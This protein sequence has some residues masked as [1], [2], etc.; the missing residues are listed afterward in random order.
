[1]L[2]ARR[3][4]RTLV[5][6]L[7]CFISFLLPSQAL[8]FCMIWLSDTQN[9]SGGYPDTFYTMTDGIVENKAAMDIRFVFHTGD[10]VS[11]SRSEQQWQVAA[12][13]M[14]RLNGKIPYLCA[15]G[16]HDVGKKYQFNNF[17]NYVDQKQ[18]PM[19]SGDALEEGRIRYTLFSAN[20]RNYIFVS[21]GFMRTG[22]NDE[23]AAWV[24]HILQSYKSYTA[25]LI[26]HSYLHS[27]GKHLTTQGKAIY[28]KIVVPNSNVWLVL[29]GHCRK[30]A[31]RT[32]ELDD[33]GDGVA[34]RTVYAVMSNY[35]DAPKGGSGYLR[36]INFG[37]TTVC[38]S[39]YSPLLDDY[40]F[41]DEPRKDSLCILYPD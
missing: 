14:Q 8:A 24:S 12:Q 10:L 4:I 21:I 37:P 13:A 29:S 26:T 34:D 33:D 23:D 20:G 38:M 31:S 35:Q 25:I 6:Y 27:D 30:P 1:M 39:T 36:I 15:A 11:A 9:Y 16:N 22:P 18:T 17:Y 19:L 7:L 28:D 2:H 41:F 32:D 40:T 3:R 5:S